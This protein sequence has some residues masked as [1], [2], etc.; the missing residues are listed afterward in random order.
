MFQMYTFYTTEWFIALLWKIPD[1]SATIYH[2]RWWRHQTETFSALQAICAG[3]HRSPVNSPHKGQWRGALMFSLTSAW[4]NGWVNNG[5]AG[6]WRCH[7]AHYDAIAMRWVNIDSLIN[8]PHVAIWRHQKSISWMWAPW[9]LVWIH[10]FFYRA[11]R[12]GQ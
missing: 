4:I 8:V 12:F 10:R 2:I 1:I 3:I 5:Q 9:L 7:R 6:D 11:L